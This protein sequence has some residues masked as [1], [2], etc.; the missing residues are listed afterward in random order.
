MFKFQRVKICTVLA[1]VASL[2]EAA[3]I[4]LLLQLG[5]ELEKHLVLLLN[6]PIL[7]FQTLQTLTHLT[8]RNNRFTYQAQQFINQARRYPN[9]AFRGSTGCSRFGGW[10]RCSG[11]E[12]CCK[13]FYRLF[14]SRNNGRIVFWNPF[15]VDTIRP[16]Q[17]FLQNIQCLIG[18][19]AIG[20]NRL[21]HRFQTIAC[22]NQHLR[23][24]ATG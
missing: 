11:L 21:T 15:M 12:L 9:H 10:R 5:S 24:I 14:H 17:D 4:H 16:I 19:R 13:R 22:M 3:H 8:R 2:C 6:I 1:G 18:G 7:M 20:G 23:H